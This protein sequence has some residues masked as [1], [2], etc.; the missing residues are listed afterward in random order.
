MVTMSMDLVFANSQTK[1]TSFRMKFLLG[2][3]EDS[4]LSGHNERFPPDLSDNFDV[5]AGYVINSGRCTDFED[6]EFYVREDISPRDIRA[7][8]HALKTFFKHFEKNGYMSDLEYNELETEMLEPETM[9]KL[10]EDATS[11]GECP[12]LESQD[13][14]GSYQSTF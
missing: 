12:E 9:D 13:N 8:E 6:G 2:Y 1:E 10:Y 11:G 4:D 3:D 7:E 14:S 5:L